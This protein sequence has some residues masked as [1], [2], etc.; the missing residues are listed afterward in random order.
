[1]TIKFLDEPGQRAEGVVIA[2]DPEKLVK[3]VNNR[4][5]YSQ[6]HKR[7]NGVVS[8]DRPEILQL[9]GERLVEPS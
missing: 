3:T 7:G 2:S 9:S 6:P 8:Y 1:M 4:N 5:K